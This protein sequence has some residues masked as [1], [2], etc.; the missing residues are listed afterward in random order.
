[1]NPKDLENIQREDAELPYSEQVEKNLKFIRNRITELRM[2]EGISERSLSLD[3][4]KGSS[5]IGQITNG[6]IVPSLVPLLQLCQRFSI[7]PSEFFDPNFHNPDLLHRAFEQ[8]KKLSD[9]DIAYLL[10]LMGKLE[11]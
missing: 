7:T 9:E 3:L 5:Y 1:M 10:V 2:A 4:G 6:K 11:K 8:L